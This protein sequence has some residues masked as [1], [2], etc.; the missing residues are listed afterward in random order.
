MTATQVT[1]GGVTLEDVVPEAI[2]TS[3]TRKLAGDRRYVFVDVPG[4]AGSVFYPEQTGDRTVQLAV[5]ILADTFAERRDA[6]RRLSLWAMRPEVLP[7]IIDDED[8]RYELAVVTSAPDVDERVNVAAVT[9][10]FRCGPYAYASVV[11]DEIETCASGVPVQFDFPD[12][13]DAEPTV[14]V[15]LAGAA[16]DVDVTVDGRTLTNTGTF[17]SGDTFTISTPGYVVVGVAIGDD[18][19]ADTYLDGLY[20]P[21]DVDMAGVSGLFP[22]LRVGGGEITVT[23]DTAVAA[24]VRVRWRERYQ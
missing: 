15:T 17:G 6:V 1:F 12:D 19:E 7:L 22:I 3:V 9:L 8:D 18:A 11:S 14:Q 13:V 5:H 20:D 23:T 4:R 16:G 10:E 21:D 24:D 2:V